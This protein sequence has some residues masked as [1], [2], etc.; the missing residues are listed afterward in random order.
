[1]MPQFLQVKT[2]RFN[3]TNFGVGL[4]IFSIGLFKKV[5]LADGISPYADAVFN[6]ADQGLAVTVEEAWLGAMAY[7]LQLY[8]DFSGYS[9][10]AVGLSWMLNIRLPFNF[11]S[12]YRATSISD[13]WRRWHI[14]LSNFLR[15]YL[16]IALGGNRRGEAR[17]YANLLTTMILGGLWHGAS[18]SFV[19]WGTLH[20]VYLVLQQLWS[21][22]A[23][24]SLVSSAAQKANARISGSAARFFSWLL[25]MLC[26]VIAWVLFRATTLDG[27][28]T[29]Y[30]AM[31][32]VE[33]AEVATV[34]WNAG[35]QSSRG[36]WLVG[37]FSLVAVWPSNSNALGLKLR[38][39]I[40]DRDSRASLVVGAS[41]L[42]ACLLI[43]IN[44]SRG[45]AGAFIYFNF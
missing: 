45:V 22:W 23:G 32:A 44:N 10:M 16:Y 35:L 29:I 13:F 17:R 31:I 18:W 28:G 40:A 14:S 20:G 33:S 7:T 39:L 2:Y 3:L 26:V 27:A 24:Q 30:G 37:F 34:L 21:R 12:P 36:W 15:D 1:M 25:T 43:L 11:N 8:F 42:L 4:A 5:V 38:V 6:A 9:D 41:G 19:I